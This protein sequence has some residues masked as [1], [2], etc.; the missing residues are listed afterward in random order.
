MPNGFFGTNELWEPYVNAFAAQYRLIVPD[1]RGHGRSTNPNDTYSERQSALDMYVL[2][3]RLEIAR[4][5]GIGFSSGAMTLL[6]MVTQQPT[7]IDA[8]ILM[9][10]TF[11]F[12]NESRAIYQEFTMDTLEPQFLDL[13]RTWHP[14]GEDQVRSLVNQFHRFKDSHDDVNFSLP[15]P[16]A[17]RARTLIIQGD[18]DEFFPVSIGLQMYQAIPRSFLWVIPNASHVLFFKVFGSTASGDDVFPEVALDFLRGKWES[19]QQ[20]A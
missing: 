4:F 1:L 18:R 15:T 7:R 13:L 17:I 5:A 19:D 11:S 2:L 8:M 12:T 16:S 6:H 14:R 20:S 10:G 3:D 9:G